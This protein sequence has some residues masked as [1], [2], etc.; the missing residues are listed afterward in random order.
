MTA[1]ALNI[2]IPSGNIS[3]PSGGGAAI[4]IS[5]AATS[6]ITVQNTGKY[7]VRIIAT[8]TNSAPALPVVGTNDPGVLILP[9][10]GMS[11]SD[12][13]VAEIAPHLGVTSAWWWAYAEGADSSVRVAHA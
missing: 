2:S 1:R 6:S 8:A 7:A 4:A 9:Y 10:T 11:V 5:D 13:L 3:I 12:M